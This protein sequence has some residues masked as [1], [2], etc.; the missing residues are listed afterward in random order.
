MDLKG[1]G[2]PCGPVV[3]THAGSYVT[4]ICCALVS[5]LQ[6]EASDMKPD[7]C[8]WEGIKMKKVIT[9]HHPCLI[10]WDLSCFSQVVRVRPVQ[11]SVLFA[12]PTPLP[13][14]HFPD[15]P[16]G[17]EHETCHSVVRNLITS[18]NQ[19]QKRLSFVF[20]NVLYVAKDSIYLSDSPFHSQYHP[21]PSH[22][23]LFPR[24]F[25]TW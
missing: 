22:A 4:K 16:Y 1:Q 12:P 5:T 15:T 8:P 10:Q 7:S 14:R 18:Q 17:T 3:L 23:E 9:C 19:K 13:K 21:E 24:H 20:L 6:M 2:K 25:M 11:V